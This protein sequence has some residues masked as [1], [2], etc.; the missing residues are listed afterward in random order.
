MAQ[1]DPGTSRPHNHYVQFYQDDSDVMARVCAYLGKGL[2]SGQAGIVIATPAHGEAIVRHLNKA[3]F[4]VDAA[5]GRGQYVALDAAGTLA[6]CMKSGSPDERLFTDV[7]GGVLARAGGRYAGLRAF[8][9]MVALLWMEGKPEAALRLEQLW[10]GLSRIHRFSLFCAYPSTPF[11]ASATEAQ[12]GSICDEH[13]HVIPSGHG[14]QE[15]A[16]ASG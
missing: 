10:N 11:F 13:S 2:E 8:G 6:Q 3:G 16:S 7:V 12:F 4:D 1:V 14:P 9:E 15:G 5:Q